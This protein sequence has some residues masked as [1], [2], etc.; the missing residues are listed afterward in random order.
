MFKT[1]NFAL[2]EMGSH[3]RLLSIWFRSITWCL[4]RAVVES[5]TT[6]CLQRR[7]SI[8]HLFPFSL[9]IPYLIVFAVIKGT[10]GCKGYHNYDA[11]RNHF[12][13]KHHWCTSFSILISSYRSN[14][15]SLYVFFFL[16]LRLRHM[17]VPRLGHWIGAT[18]AGLC[19]SHSN[20]SSKPC[21]WPT[22]QLTAKLDP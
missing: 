2:K 13:S 4:W 17:K 10:S 8:Y 14:L 3:R 11:Q 7:H 12:C 19:H 16:G 22:P 9:S 20:T 21:L 15:P 1:L 6:F 5:V 18:A